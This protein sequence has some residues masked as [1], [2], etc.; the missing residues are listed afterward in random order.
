LIDLMVSMLLL[1][2]A[3]VAAWF[4]MLSTIALQQDRVFRCPAFDMLRAT[5]QWFNPTYWRYLWLIS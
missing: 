3:A 5:T 2:M 1:G 4:G